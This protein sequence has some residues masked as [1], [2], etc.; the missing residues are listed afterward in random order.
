LVRPQDSQQNHFF[1]RV[2]FWNW[3]QSLHLWQQV[4]YF[5]SYHYTPDS[6]EQGIIFAQQGVLAREQAILLT[7]IEFIA[8]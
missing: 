4:A 5:P 1:V 3:L 2:K 7:R 6:T 8:G